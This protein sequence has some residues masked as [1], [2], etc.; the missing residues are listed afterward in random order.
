M[1]SSM[2]ISSGIPLRE[3][4]ESSLTGGGDLQNFKVDNSRMKEK[5]RERL[6]IAQPSTPQAMTTLS[7]Y[8]DVGT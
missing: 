1:V 2:F 7:E 6:G 4:N 8:D 5:I 3:A